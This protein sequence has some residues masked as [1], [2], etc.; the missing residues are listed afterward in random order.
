M[1]QGPSILS[2]V[3]PL[4]VWS[5]RHITPSCE[6]LRALEPV[7]VVGILVASFTSIS[8]SL[9]VIINDMGK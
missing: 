9:L 4:Q 3:S 5:M 8:V 6:Q 7:P 1:Q 2:I